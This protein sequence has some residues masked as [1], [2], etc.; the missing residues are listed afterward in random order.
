MVKNEKVYEAIQA[1]VT[2]PEY[3][4]ESIDNKETA[5][6]TIIHLRNHVKTVINIVY[7]LH[8][9]NQDLKRIADMLQTVD[10][11]KTKL[12]SKTIDK[13]IREDHHDIMSYDA[14][15]GGT[16]NFEWVKD[17]GL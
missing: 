5:V 1:I 17:S 9:N 13:T 10:K 7:Q 16:Y 2:S 11:A 8:E 3:K 15:K 12:F 14:R 4:L 6:S